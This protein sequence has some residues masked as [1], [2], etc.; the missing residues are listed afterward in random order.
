MARKFFKSASGKKP[1]GK[2]DRD[3]GLRSKPR[4]SSSFSVGYEVSTPRGG[5]METTANTM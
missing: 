4:T 2:V 5:G 3:E 1:G